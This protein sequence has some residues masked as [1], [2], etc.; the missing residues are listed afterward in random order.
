[1]I[2]RDWRA[3]MTDFADVRLALLGTAWDYTEAPAEFIARL[4]AFEAAGI[5]VC[6]PPALVR[7]NADKLYLRDLADAGAP[8]IP[9]LWSDTGSAAD[10]TAAFD[11]FDCDRLVIKRRVGAGA[12]GQ[13]SFSRTAPP[14]DGWAIGRP[15]M[16]QPFLPA[17]ASEGEYSLIFIDGGF[18]HAL[19]KHAAA[20][21]YRIQSLYGGRETPV[22]PPAADIASAEAVL[23]MLPG[24]DAPL[25]ARIDMVRGPDGMLALMEAELIEPYLYPEQDA[26]FGARW[27]QAVRRRIG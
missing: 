19:C 21:D 20:G 11:H 27:A 5:I 8:S 17:I 13:E 24:N 22:T 12:V 18:S 9:T 15:A 16:I 6:N 25:Y 23:A 2:E 14:P 4:E 7:W 26:G 3:P 1:V 10:V